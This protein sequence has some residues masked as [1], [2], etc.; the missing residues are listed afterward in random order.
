MKAKFESWIRRLAARA[1]SRQG[2]PRQECAPADPA[3]LERARFFPGQLITA[4]DLTQDQV[5]LREKQ[6][7]HNR[8]LHGWGIICGLDVTTAGGCFVEVSSG[9]ALDPMGDEIVV[10]E[11]VRLDVCAENRTDEGRTGYLAVRYAM[12]ATRPIAA[13]ASANEDAT[14]YRRTRDEFELGVLKDLPR[15]EESWVILADVTV[16]AGEVSLDP[17]RHRRYVVSSAARGHNR[18]GSEKRVGEQQAE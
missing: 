6:R 11:S 17:E 10:A 9:Y 14:E 18:H 2:I 3:T 15:P 7:R 5:Y 13:E 4:E 16:A 1:G 12:R 8:L